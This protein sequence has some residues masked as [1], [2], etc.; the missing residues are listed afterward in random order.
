MKLSL[1]LLT[2]QTIWE[3]QLACSLLWIPSTITRILFIVSRGLWGLCSIVHELV[4]VAVVMAHDHVHHPLHQWLHNVVLE[5]LD[6]L[7]KWL[8]G[9][10]ETSLK[11]KT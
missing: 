1:T 3:A 6:W 7:D 10:T 4:L 5:V 2:E 8:E 11:S 9:L